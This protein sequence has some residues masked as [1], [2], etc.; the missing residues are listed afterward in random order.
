MVHL[1]HTFHIRNGMVRLGHYTI[2]PPSRAHDG[3]HIGEYPDIWTAYHAAR[4]KGAGSI[5][6]YCADDFPFVMRGPDDTRGMA[7]CAK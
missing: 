3:R 1:I 7:W 5:Y 4:E 6:L 2:V